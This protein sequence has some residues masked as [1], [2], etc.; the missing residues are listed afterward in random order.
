MGN[1]ELMGHT[2]VLRHAPLDFLA[3]HPFV[4]ERID[5]TAIAHL[6]ALHRWPD[7]RNFPGHIAAGDPGHRHRQSGH[8]AP[9]EDIEIIQ[10]ARLDPDEQ[11]AR[12]DLR[13][14]KIAI[15]DI[16]D[17]AVPFDHR[18]LHDLP[19]LPG[20]L[21]TRAFHRHGKGALGQH[22][23]EMKLRRRSS[24]NIVD[25]IEIIGQCSAGRL[26]DRR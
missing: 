19:L 11:I 21:H 24:E 2:A 4:G 20:S 8:A 17:P 16:L 22:T 7:R 12:A 15:D 9:H 13:I 25:R 10:A 18:C 5:E 23:L 3:H 6:P 26:A 14:R 1:D